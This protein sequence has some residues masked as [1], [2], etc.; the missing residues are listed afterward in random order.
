[1]AA[2]YKGVQI[3]PGMQG[4]DL[5]AF[6]AAIDSTQG[7]SA[8]PKTNTIQDTPKG[9][10]GTINRNTGTLSGTLPP[11][12][13]P[14]GQPGTIDRNTGTITN[15]TPKPQS[16][17]GLG[18]FKQQPKS[19]LLDFANALDQ[20]TGLAKKKL[21]ASQ[22][23][24][25]MPH[26]GTAMASDFSSI[27][28]RMNSASDNTAA[29]LTNRA[30]EFA[31]PE[32]LS[33]G[34]MTDPYGNLYE[35]QTDANGQMI[36]Q[37]LLAQGAPADVAKA[38]GTTQATK[39]KVQTGNFVY[40]EQDYAEDLAALTA[41]DLYDAAGNPNRGPDG[42][43]NPAIYYQL[44]KEWINKGGLAADFTKTFPIK[45]F[46]N[47]ANTLSQYPELKALRGDKAPSSSGSSGGGRSA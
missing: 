10:S 25:M 45:N 21:N 8:A 26:K 36:G 3:P 7:G 13:T 22:L 12:D 47:P 29:N 5:A 34:T 46:I 14:K 9:Q 37:R 11:L 23:G 1:M 31:Q 43:V 28:S 17:F 40:T 35:I 27:L 39:P 20:A 19:T 2:S 32:Q 4:A 41:M 16:G 42:Y 15:T 30:L 24:I 33:Y 44:Y 6:M 18:A 38:E